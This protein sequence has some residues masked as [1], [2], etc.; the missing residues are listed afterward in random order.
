MSLD[1][2]DKLDKLI[3]LIVKI[4]LAL[5][6]AL[7]LVFA[8][9]TYHWDNPQGHKTDRT[10]QVYLDRPDRPAYPVNPNT[11]TGWTLETK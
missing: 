10:Y 2:L 7:S 1:K 4:S 6:F 3:K 11:T 9:M 5:L 8:R